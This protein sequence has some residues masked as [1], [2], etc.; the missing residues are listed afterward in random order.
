MA[1]TRAKKAELKD[2]QKRALQRI[3][4]S[5]TEE[6]RRLQ[7][8]KTLLMASDGATDDTIA[9]A[10]GLNKNSV[11]NTIAKFH[12]LGVEGALSDLARPGR[13][14]VIG[15]GAKTWVKSVACT[16]P[17]ELGHAQEMWTTRTLAAH[18]KA[19]CAQAGFPELSSVSASKVQTILNQAVQK[20]N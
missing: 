14:A 1:R 10:V 15:D 12:D 16:K 8:A 9:T 3:A 17:V 2:E 4:N 13:P 7:R 18:I 20:R 19:H 11:R 6:V 5:R